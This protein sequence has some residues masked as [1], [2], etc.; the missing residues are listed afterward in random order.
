MILYL[1]H[2]EITEGPAAGAL[3]SGSAHSTSVARTW[4]PGT[5][6]HHSFVSDHAVVLADIQQQEDWQRMLAQGKSF[7]GE[8][9]KLAEDVSSG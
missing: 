2:Q 4:F 7:S 8:G 5:D 1:A 9:G 3:W 6:T